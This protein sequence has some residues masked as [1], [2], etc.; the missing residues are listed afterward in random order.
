L[1]EK[2]NA[3]SEPNDKV[4]IHRGHPEAARFLANRLN[5]MGVDLPYAYRLRHSAGLGHAF[6]NTL[7]YFDF[8]RTGFDYPI[9]PIHVNCYG[10]EL[11]RRRGGL[12]APGQAGAEPDPP[13]PSARV[14]FD[15]GRAIAQVFSA[16]KYRVAIVAS[17]SWSHAFLT[18]K[19]DWLFPDH[20]SD[21]SRLADL[22]DGRLSAWRELDRKTIE[23][24]G[25]Q[26]FL[27]W[28]CLAGAMHEIG[29]RAEV[30]DYLE[31]YIL[32]SDKCFA[33][34]AGQ[35]GKG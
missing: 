5:E 7:L 34:F 8:D 6:I 26:E 13:G 35:D 2:G 1:F 24:A 3:W 30:V 11:I 32:N 17:S 31:S 12:L 22:K 23:D 16:S 28:V 20:E 25:Q 33:R 10:G 27:N 15:T 29:A 9:I 18:A 19:N 21:R 4:F 14:C